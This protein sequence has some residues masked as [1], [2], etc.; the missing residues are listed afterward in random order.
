M[1]FFIPMI[2]FC[3]SC[4]FYSE[5]ENVDITEESSWCE[6]LCVQANKWADQCGRESLDLGQ[7]KARFEDNQW[8]TDQ[9]ICKFNTWCYVR[10]TEVGFCEPLINSDT[11]Y[12]QP[13]ISIEESGC[14]D[15]WPDEW[16]PYRR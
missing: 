12:W 3:S 13:H 15:E 16:L 10:Y 2:V 6:R 8:P 1:K 9:S 5:I 14:V 4:A 7:C 11:E